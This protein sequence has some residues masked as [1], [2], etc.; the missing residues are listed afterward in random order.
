MDVRELGRRLGV[1]TVIEGSV[2][3]DRR[4]LRITVQAVD[5]ETGYHLWSGNFDRSG[6]AT[7]RTQEEVSEAITDALL[8]KLLLTVS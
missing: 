3:R 6:E 2:R 1:N 8:S 5:A 4:R 7:F